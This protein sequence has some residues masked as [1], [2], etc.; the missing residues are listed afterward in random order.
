MNKSVYNFRKKG[1]RYKMNKKCYVYQSL[2][3]SENISRFYGFFVK[4]ILAV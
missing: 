2:S 3:V 1:N 4:A